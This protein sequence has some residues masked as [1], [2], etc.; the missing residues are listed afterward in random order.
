MGCSA[1]SLQLVSVADRRVRQGCNMQLLKPKI[2]WWL[3]VV[4]RKKTGISL[5][6]LLRSGLVLG[7]VLAC[8]VLV[9]FGFG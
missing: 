2:N 3:L 5:Q 9:Q 1:V 7:K 4:R 6:H 8:L